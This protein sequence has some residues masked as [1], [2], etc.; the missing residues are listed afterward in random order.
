VDCLCGLADG[1]RYKTGIDA[2]R[3]VCNDAKKVLAGK[4]AQEGCKKL[5]AELAG[6]DDR[7]KE[8]YESQ[9][10]AVPVECP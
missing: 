5:M 7:W 6:Q 9:G 4:N 2:H 3:E 1:Y 10:V 8:P